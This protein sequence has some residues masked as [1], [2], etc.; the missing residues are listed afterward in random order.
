MSSVPSE[1]LRDILLPLDRW[2]LDD[3][4]F[5]NRRFL[6]LILEHMSDVCLRQVDTASTGGLF[7][8]KNGDTELL[9]TIHLID[10]PERNISNHHK[11]AA[12]LVSQFV[13]A[14]R[15]SQVKWLALDRKY[16]CLDVHSSLVENA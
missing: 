16:N 9:T 6:Q 11:D 5:T 12:H 14:L 15:G 4:Q 8:H 13:Q 10:R 3:V 2:T 1:V 7:T